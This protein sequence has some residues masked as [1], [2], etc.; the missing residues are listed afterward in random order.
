MNNTI[1]ELASTRN[2]FTMLALIGKASLEDSLH[3]VENLL[4]SALQAG[5]DSAAA[6]YLKYWQCGLE[7]IERHLQ[8]GKIQDCHERYV[9]AMMPLYQRLEA[10]VI[11]AYEKTRQTVLTMLMKELVIMEDDL[12]KLTFLKVVVYHSTVGQVTVVKTAREV[13]EQLPAER[14]MLFLGC[15]QRRQPTDDSYLADLRHFLML[16]I[17]RET[18]TDLRF[19]VTEMGFKLRQWD[20]AAARFASNQLDQYGTLAEDIVKLRRQLDFTWGYHPV[21]GADDVITVTSAKEIEVVLVVNVDPSLSAEECGHL[22]FQCE[23]TAK[24]VAYHWSKR[25]NYSYTLT[26]QVH[27]NNGRRGYAFVYSKNSVDTPVVV[28]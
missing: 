28:A 20:V 3:I 17:F 5:G 11:T 12:A 26:I 21:A 14:A 13:W 22:H 1:K 23:T 19:L 2:D 9:G 6:P 27:L 8:T 18:R 15:I 25:T 10:G 4:I 16:R 24:D 7:E